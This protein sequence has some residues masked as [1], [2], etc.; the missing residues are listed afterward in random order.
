MYAFDRA[1]GDVRWKRRTAGTPT[2]VARIGRTIY[3]ASFVDELIALNLA[4]G[5]LRWKFATGMPNPDCALPPTPVVVDDRVFYAG[6]DGIIHSLNAQSGRLTLEARSR[7]T[8]GNQANCHR[9]FTL[10]RELDELLVS[11]FHR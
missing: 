9:Q 1:T 4:D 5:S 2:D 11:D 10:C 6:L 7:K 3:A 8:G